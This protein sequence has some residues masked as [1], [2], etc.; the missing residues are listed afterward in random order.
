MVTGVPAGT[1]SIPG[2]PSFD[3]LAESGTAT[4]PAVA[5]G[6]GTK[7]DAD[8]AYRI[9][10]LQGPSALEIVLVCSPGPVELAWSTGPGTETELGAQKVACTDDPL[11]IGWHRDP[12]TAGVS[13]LHVRAPA[14][15]S[16][17]AL[18]RDISDS[19]SP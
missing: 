18:I 1:D 9:A 8:A 7:P 2:L 15:T 3:R 13:E 10:S 4:A 16:W 19:T 14:G 12:A 5:R 11:V 17:E 6:S